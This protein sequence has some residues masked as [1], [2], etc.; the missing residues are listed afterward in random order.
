MQNVIID[1]VKGLQDIKYKISF[2]APNY[3]AP[4]RIDQEVIFIA[5]RQKGISILSS[6]ELVVNLKTIDM[7]S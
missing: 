4:N 2:R 7:I 3:P 1:L 6:Q 5:A